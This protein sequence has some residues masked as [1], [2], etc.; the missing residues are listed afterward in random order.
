M[1]Q[2]HPALCEILGKPPIIF[3][4]NQLILHRGGL[5]ALLT[6]SKFPDWTRLEITFLSIFIL[7]TSF[8]KIFILHAFIFPISPLPFPFS[9]FPWDVS[10]LLLPKRFPTPTDFLIVLWLSLVFLLE[11]GRVVHPKY[12]Q[13]KT[14]N[15]FCICVQSFTHREKPSMST[16]EK[17]AS[18]AIAAHDPCLCLTE[19]AEQSIIAFFLSISS[20]TSL[21][22]CSMASQNSHFFMHFCTVGKPESWTGHVCKNVEDVDVWRS[23]GMANYLTFLYFSI[24]ST[25]FA[26]IPIK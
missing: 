12:F 1:S 26:H 10:L 5:V 8:L 11:D 2:I 18:R 13:G 19:K 17:A 6:Q 15:V 25:G 20:F 21:F 24:W 14:Q 16:P 4:R 7:F 22:E 3:I 9:L 23:V